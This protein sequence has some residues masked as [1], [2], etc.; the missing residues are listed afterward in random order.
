MLCSAY[1][2]Q[3]FYLS[4]RRIQGKC[5]LLQLLLICVM[6][7]AFLLH[8]L[9]LSLSTAICLSLKTLQ[10][11]NYA[12]QGCWGTVS[13]LV[14]LTLLFLCYCSHGLAPMSSKTLH[15]SFQVSHGKQRELPLMCES[16]IF[17]PPPF[18][19]LSPHHGHTSIHASLTLVHMFPHLKI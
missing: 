4:S 7:G 15:L 18:S 16:F 1:E 3:N 5:L 17:C 11:S 10:L 6:L 14:L 9:L 12:H 13:S 2:G 19:S 8:L